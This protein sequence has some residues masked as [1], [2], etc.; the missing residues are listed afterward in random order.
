MRFRALTRICL[1]LCATFAGVEAACA[2]DWHARDGQQLDRILPQI[3]RTHPGRF[4]D[5]EGPWP[6]P[7]GQMRYRIKW[8]MPDGRIVWF[9]A[10]ARSGRLLGPDVFRHE[11]IPPGSFQRGDDQGARHFDNDGG[12]PWP[13]DHGNGQDWGGQRGGDGHGHRRRGDGPH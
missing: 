3:R 5:A 1:L 8:M 9:D 7:D 4:Y 11:P 12:D 10:D 2:E 6:G 13:G